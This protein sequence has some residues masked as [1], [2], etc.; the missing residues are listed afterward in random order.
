MAFTFAC[1]LYFLPVVGTLFKKT[2]GG[3]ADVL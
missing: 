1:A 3:F 2:A